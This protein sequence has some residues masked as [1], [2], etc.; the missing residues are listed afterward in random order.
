MLTIV[1]VL[2]GNFVP[3]IASRNKNLYIEDDKFSPKYIE[4]QMG[5]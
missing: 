5:S 2:G 4:S 3:S 1:S